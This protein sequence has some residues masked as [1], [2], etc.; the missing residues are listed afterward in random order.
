M[1][2]AELTEDE[3]ADLAMNGGE[4]D[5]AGAELDHYLVIMPDGRLSIRA[6]RESE[7]RETAANGDA[8]Q[9]GNLKQVLLRFMQI[10]SARTA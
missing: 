7:L 2:L 6:V 3:L 9:G 1:N 4:L 8:A 10:Y 5:F